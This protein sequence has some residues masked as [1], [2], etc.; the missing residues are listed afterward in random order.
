[1]PN[2]VNNK[3]LHIDNLMPDTIW[4]TFFAKPGH[5]QLY[6]PIACLSFALN[7][8]F[9]GAD[10]TGYHAV[11]IS[12]HILN[13]WLLFLVINTLLRI[14]SSSKAEIPEGVLSVSFLAALLWAL[15]PVHTMAVTYIV[16]RMALLA[17]L[18]YL[19]GILFY[20]QLRLSKH[21]GRRVI[22]ASLCCIS[23]LLAVGSKENAA[24]FP[25]GLLLIEG[26]FFQDL[27]DATIR[28][29]LAI[30]S[31][32][33]LFS[34]VI[35]GSALF[36]NGNLFASLN[37]S[38]SRFYTPLQRLI[39]QPRV[40][41]FYLSQLFYP[42][43]SSLS[44]EHDIIF[45]TTLFSPW[46]TL[47]A[48]IAI[49]A[50]VIGCMIN[51]HK[52]TLLCFSLLFF[53]VNHAIESSII[54]L[55]LVFEHRNYLPSLFLFLPPVIGLSSLITK[56]KSTNRQICVLVCALIPTIV[57]SFGYWTYQRN[58]AWKTKETL[59]RDAM[60]KAP[61]Q[62]RPISHVAID[63]A[64]STH[65]THKDYM[66]ALR[67]FA[68]SL[69]L[70]MAR[71]DMRS[72]IIGNIGNVYFQLGR[73]DDASTYQHKAVQEA[74]KN[75]KLRYDLVKTLIL[76][77][78][79]DEAEHHADILSGEGRL[80]ADYHNIHG[81]IILWKNR[82]REA[83]DHFR[84]AFRLAPF[85]PNIMLNT[86]LALSLA[87]SYKNAEWFLRVADKIQKKDMMPLLALIENS[88]RA[89]DP[90]LAM[91]FTRRLFSWFPASRI[92]ANL[93]A[94]SENY[95]TIPLSYDLIRESIESGYRMFC[96]PNSSTENK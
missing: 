36:L 35:F 29:R 44:V 70:N 62:V 49:G 55:E 1:M 7:W 40:L 32:L 82:P 73:L 85:Q 78:K 59:W 52:Q 17:A 81:F 38:G 75:K 90:E 19:A 47:P 58:A 76:Q 50:I 65:P 53:F 31:F 11:N 61:R 42:L 13:A 80:Y 26:A 20:I 28:N 96:Q 2:I 56:Y 6:R 39:T 86:G 9:G 4:Q 12:I 51:L 68:K 24:I 5:H 18:F 91:T 64:W 71:R 21:K 60:Q 27:S 45:S 74:P 41:I 69:P 92:R 87:G 54:N 67:L 33:L 48:I 22:F 34:I 79:W 66:T 30:V 16:Q 37:E 94:P 83:L 77:G 14:S 43:P 15:N 72:D 63:L 46:T 10:T 95:S 84:K 88:V 23:Y 93:S 89:G 57:T 3:S 8:Y 25:M